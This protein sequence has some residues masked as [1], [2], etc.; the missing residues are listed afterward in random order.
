MGNTQSLKNLVYYRLED[1]K[2]KKKKIID[3]LEKEVDSKSITY[4]SLSRYNKEI[5]KIAASEKELFL[6]VSQE[7]NDWDNLQLRLVEWAKKTFGDQIHQRGTWS[8]LKEEVDELGEDFEDIEEYA[9]VMILFVQVAAYSGYSMNDVFNAA[10]KKF[11]KNQNRTWK[12]SG[13]G[14]FQHSNKEE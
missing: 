11:L 14:F 1:L 9:D 4:P 12:K 7:Y 8:K 3:Q 13:D 6:L 5:E 2:N 10:R